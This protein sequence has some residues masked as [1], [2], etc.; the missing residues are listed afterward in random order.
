MSGALFCDMEQ[1]MTKTSGQQ[2]LRACSSTSWKIISTH[3]SHYLR[4]RFEEETT[5][6][7]IHCEGVGS[8]GPQNCRITPKNGTGC[9]LMRNV[10]RGVQRNGAQPSLRS[11]PG[12]AGAHRFRTSTETFL[13]FAAPRRGAVDGDHDGLRAG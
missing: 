4:L 3:F 6:L 1:A 13:T 8:S 2:W 7:E 12:N 5:R 10:P 9:C 11:R